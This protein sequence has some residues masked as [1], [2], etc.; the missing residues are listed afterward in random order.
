MKP[1]GG[2][3]VAALAADLGEDSRKCSC[4]S[5]GVLKE[6]PPH[7]EPYRC[8]SHHGACYCF[9]HVVVL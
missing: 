6:K 2:M 4:G 3:G 9:S 1:K 5:G 7:G 8:G